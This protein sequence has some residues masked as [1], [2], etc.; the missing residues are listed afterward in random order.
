MTMLTNEV[1]GLLGQMPLMQ[2]GGESDHK[3]YE[4][5]F[6]EQERSVFDVDLSHNTL[7]DRLESFYSLFKANEE[8]DEHVLIKDLPFTNKAKSEVQSQAELPV[9]YLSRITVTITVTVAI[10]VTVTI[11][12]G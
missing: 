3:M 4:I 2:M 10:T 12:T 6:H 5:D 8:E 9:A 1:R 11:S 7:A